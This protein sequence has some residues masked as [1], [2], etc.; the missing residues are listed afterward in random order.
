MVI[1][2]PERTIRDVLDGDASSGAYPS[3]RRFIFGYAVFFLGGIF[4]YIYS[5]VVFVYSRW[6][7]S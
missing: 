1:W 3:R 2:E 7:C 4:A 6:V 5:V